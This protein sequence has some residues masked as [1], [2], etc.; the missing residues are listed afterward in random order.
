MFRNLKIRSKIFV[1]FAAV[2]IA[3]ITIAIYGAIQ[4]MH[5]DSQ[6]SLAMEFPDERVDILSDLALEMM[7]AR[8][9]MNRAAMYIHDPGDAT[10][11]IMQ[12]WQ[13]VL[14]IRARMNTLFDRFHVNVYA[15]P[16]F[17]AADRADRMQLMNAY[18]REV[19]RY[20][21]HYIAGLIV[22]ARMFDEAAAI[23]IV[24]DG[25]ATV[26][27]ANAYHE[28]LLTAA[29]NLMYTLGNDLSRQTTAT[30]RNLSIIA[31]VS[32]A[33]SIVII[34]FVSRS[35]SMPINRVVTSLGEVSRGNLNVNIDRTNISKDE[36]GALTRDVI[37]LVD[38]VKSIV[39]DLSKFE[40]NY[41][42]E[43]DI[44]YRMDAEKYQNS[45]REMVEGSN[46]LLDNVVSDILGFLATLA[47]VSG[48]NF[49]PAI[50]EL[51]GKKVVLKNA[52][53][54]TTENMKAVSAE[55]NAMINSIAA[56]GDLTFKINE[57]QY[58]GDW[59][60]IMTGLN[61]ITTAI[62]APV[63]ITKVVLNE[64]AA[65]N[66]DIATINKDL[67]AKGLDIAAE[68]YNGTFREM[69]ASGDETLENV[70]SYVNELNEMLAEIAKGDLRKT[71]TRNYAGMFD[72][73]KSSV[74]T[75]NDTLHKTM[76]EI[77]TAANQ[78]LSG[79]TQISSSANDLASGAQQ[80]ASSVQELNASIDMISQQTS[81][82]AENA[83][84]ANDLSGK[85]TTNAQ[86]GNEAMGQM[87]E[88][89][90]KIKESSNDISKIVKTIQDIAFQTNLLALNASVEAARAGEHGKGFAVVA[91][92]VRTLAG[93]SQEA[94]TQ[95]TE[96]IQDSINRVESGSSIAETTAGS[97]DAIVTSASEV[98]EIIQKISTSSKEQAEAIRQVSSGLAQI[99]SVVQSN[100]AVSQETAAASQELNSQA[101]VLRQ[102]VAFFKL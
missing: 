94:A 65:G 14:A 81:L 99:S 69:I 59:R 77:S 43:G 85:S 30:V 20:F 39:E 53:L 5:V 56:K 34:L 97:L 58:E 52:I 92:E 88:A 82:N 66:F 93:R 24:R 19:I 45:F 50:K 13:G 72:S 16:T 48:G 35:I 89:M 96:L 71:I 73:I 57:A 91:D 100:S 44:E 46:K 1:G 36:T 63:E 78:V 101:E 70:A 28:Q 68:S 15:D 42:V 12:Q 84:T 51:P 83:I 47:E 62:N 40:H 26:N 31:L 76:S 38:V 90:A 60:E 61:S 27:R 9:T 2:L 23:Q 54:S 8:R 33:L 25:V 80:Q 29:N 3:T 22:Y 32:I 4:I 79:A 37:G 95:T 87:V 98:L 10:A 64:M 18:E 41:N 74:N 75:I 21:D 17:T 6:Y 102:L 7:D 67:T 49:N 86:S 55:V 11:G